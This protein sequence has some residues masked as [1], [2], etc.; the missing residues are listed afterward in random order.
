MD[1]RWTDRDHVASATF[2]FSCPSLPLHEHRR[3]YP[4]HRQHSVPSA[5][6]APFTCLGQRGG[7]HH[8]DNGPD[9]TELAQISSTGVPP[10]D[11]CVPH[12]PHHPSQPVVGPYDPGLT[13][14][15]ISSSS[16]VLSPS[17]SKRRLSKNEP[18]EAGKKLIVTEQESAG[19]N[20]CPVQ[21]SATK[22]NAFEVRESCS[23][24]I[25]S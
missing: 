22:S 25:G 7:V 10:P 9:P 16:N 17:P 8:R 14:A 2:H 4:H 20:T 6:V 5:F 3:G 21:R 11:R 13:A 12:Q 24:V 1:A 23:I 15:P 19:L 18:E